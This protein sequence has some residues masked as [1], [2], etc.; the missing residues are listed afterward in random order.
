MA[1]GK[2]TLRNAYL[3][4]RDQ[5]PLRRLIRNLWKGHLRGLVHERSHMTHSGQPKVAYGSKASA[6]KAATKM[7]AKTGNY[8]SNYKCLFCDG[9]HLGKN[10]DSNRVHPDEAK[11]N[12]PH[13]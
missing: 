3:A 1:V 10:R 2:I 9:Y 8:F 5:L 11:W 12:I 6:E 13:G 4:F 7:M